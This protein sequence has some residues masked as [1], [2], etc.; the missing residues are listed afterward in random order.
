MNTKHP[1]DLISRL[2]PCACAGALSALLFIACGDPDP[3]CGPGTGTPSC[4]T[5]REPSSG[6]DTTP[7]SPDLDASHG[8]DGERADAIYVDA[9]DA[10]AEGDVDGQVDAPVDGAIDG[11]LE[12]SVD[13]PVDAAIDAMVLDATGGAANDVSDAAPDGAGD[14]PCDPSAD[15]RDAPCTVNEAFGVFVATSGTDDATGTRAEPLRTVTQGISLAARSGRSR[16]FV[17]QGEYSESVSLGGVQGDVSLYGGLDCIDG[18]SWTG[19]PAQVTAQGPSNALV[20]DSSSEITIEDFSF[21]AP[22]AIGQDGAGAGLSSIAAWLTNA[23]VTFRRVTFIAGKGADG[24]PGTAGDAAPNY[25]VGQTAAPSG[26]PYDYS[27]A[28]LGAGGVN[29]CSLGGALSQ[30]GAGGSPGDPSTLAGYPGGPGSAVPAPLGASS[31]YDGAGGAPPAQG[32][33][34][35]AGAGDPGASGAAGPAGVSS[36]TYGVLLAS[37]WVPSSGGAGG[38]GNPGQGG[39]GGAGEPFFAMGATFGGG[40]GGAGGCGGAGGGG[41]QGG[42]ASFALVSIQSLVAFFDCSLITSDGGQGGAGG[43]GQPGQAGGLGAPGTCGG[44]PGGNGAGGSGGAGG[45]GGISV[46]IVY[47]ERIPVLDSQTSFTFGAAGAGGLGGAPGP[48]ATTAG[49]PGVD[50]APGQD[51]LGGLALAVLNLS[52]S[53]SPAP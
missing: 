10:T 4:V 47:Q 23:T 3:Q 27:L 35:G 42:G 17:C 31:P 5:P 51:G 19:A 12:T 44:G 15:P 34:L 28:A 25:P 14:A 38:F 39:G 2:R 33:T 29:S 20:V 41:G 7:D 9:L 36:T 18:W 11:P 52:P 22:D 26:T 48:L 40:G 37:G 8:S 1:F 13:A 43:A 24:A 49:E 50:G 21:T 45:T 46:G 53:K 16:V 30:G 6:A 32:C